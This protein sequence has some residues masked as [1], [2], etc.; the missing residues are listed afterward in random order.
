MIQMPLKPG[1]KHIK[2]FGIIKIVN[3]KAL[4]IKSMKRKMVWPSIW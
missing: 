2:D 1:I 4:N 3:N